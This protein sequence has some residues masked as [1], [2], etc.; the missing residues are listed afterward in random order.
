MKTAIYCSAIA[1]ILAGGVVRADSFD[2]LG[3]E[4]PL[5]I[6]PGAHYDLSYV[7]PPQPDT[8]NLPSLLDPKDENLLVEFQ[9]T[10]SVS[11]S[12][13]GHSQEFYDDFAV[14]AGYSDYL[15]DI[16]TDINGDALTIDNIGFILSPTLI[17]LENLNLDDNPPP[18]GSFN[19]PFISGNGT[20]GTTFTEQSG[21]ILAID[22]PAPTPLP[23]SSWAILACFAGILIFRWPG[24]RRIESHLVR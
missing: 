22:I 11:G 10:D 8:S 24:R 1:L 17:P 18:S 7:N 19:S 21:G 3:P 5:S 2:P 4:L 15:V 12:N 23:K 20:G 9:A 14:P 6:G 16:P 13:N